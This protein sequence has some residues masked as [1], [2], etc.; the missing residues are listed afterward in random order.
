MTKFL[1]ILS[2][3]L[4]VS[5]CGKEV[6]YRIEGKLTNLEDQTIYVV[7]ESEENHLVD[8]ILCKKPGQFELK[9]PQ[10]GFDKA[11]LF[12]NNRTKWVSVY[13][14]PGE[15]IT[16]SGDALYPLLIQ[17]KGGDIN[18]E[19]SSIRKQY[20][21]LI[22]EQTD[23]YNALTNGKADKD[24][25]AR[26]AN[27][28]LQLNEQMQ[29]Y[30]KSHSKEKASVV[31]IQ[32][33][34]TNADDTSKLDELLATLDPKLNDFYLVNELEQ[35]SARAKRTAIGA[36]A[37][38]FTVKNVYGKSVSLDSFPQRYLLITFTAPW[39]DMCQP[40]NLYL[41][42]ISKRYAKE[43]LDLLLI[44]LDDDMKG[45]RE[46]LKKDSIAWNL[47][48]DS[49][50]QAAKLIDLYNVSALPRCFLIDE[51][52]KIILKTENGIEIKQTLEKVIE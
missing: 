15:K 22:K 3:L 40:Q 41:D 12:F 50:G 16:L 43:K 29:D 1:L 30:I 20:A 48:T 8:T 32:M 31:L 23:L 2:I 14:E 38:N 28:N 4:F 25:T 35:Y 13:L 24:V 46:L 17:A 51:E 5:S 34:F 27:V 21:A 47:V 19:L 26:L 10:E 37:P 45:I 9:Q 42:E 44:S 33:F 18:N 36:E 7:F 39:C 49:A 52:G 11:T 6:A